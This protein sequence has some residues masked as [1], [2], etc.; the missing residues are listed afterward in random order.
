MPCIVCLLCPLHDVVIL[1][2]ITRSS[3]CPQG[4]H[5]W[6]E[7]KSNQG[8]PAGAVQLAVRI[9]RVNGREMDAG[10]SAG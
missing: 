1:C 4:L 6:Y 3:L 5:G 10:A 8:N 7:L 9:V 2:F